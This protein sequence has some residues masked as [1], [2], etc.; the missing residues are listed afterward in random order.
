MLQAIAMVLKHPISTQI[1]SLTHFKFDMDETH[2]AYILIHE[3]V[4]DRTGGSFHNISRPVQISPGTE[5]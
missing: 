1:S 2:V 5:P 3:N 4:I